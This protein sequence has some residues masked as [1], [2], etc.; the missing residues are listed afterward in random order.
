MQVEHRTYVYEVLIRFDA[1]G[2][3]GSH[4][5]DVE[6]WYDP[7][8]GKVI[9][10]VEA[11]PRPVTEQELADLIGA[12]NAKAIEDFDSVLDVRSADLKQQA[13]Q[14]RLDAEA[15]NARAAAAE[16]ALAEA[17]AFLKT[18]ADSLG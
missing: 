1:D 6:E 18:A 2:Y 10:A 8:T 11:D 12:A 17:R 5:K 7:E 3:R 9:N 14:H 16:A 13:E 15:A 4:V